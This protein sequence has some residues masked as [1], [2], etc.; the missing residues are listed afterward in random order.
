[1][2]H[3]RLFR[4]KTKES[5][6]QKKKTI[7]GPLCP[8]LGKTE[9]SSKFCFYQYFLKKLWPSIIVPNLKKVMSGFQ[10][11]L[12]S[13]APIHTCMEHA[14]HET[15]HTSYHSDSEINFLSVN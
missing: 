6:F 5:I 10:V 11:T 3:F 8:F 9:C 2:F 14:Y 1:M 15:L 13:E 12:V 4:E 7:F